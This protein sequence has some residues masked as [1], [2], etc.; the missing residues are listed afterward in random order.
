MER[1]GSQ[2]SSPTGTSSVPLLQIKDCSQFSP[3]F[4]CRHWAIMSDNTNCVKLK[5]PFQERDFYRDIGDGFPPLHMD[6]L[7]TSSLP[8]LQGLLWFRLWYTS[9]ITLPLA[10]DF[11]PVISLVNRILWSFLH[12][13]EA[14]VLLIMLLQGLWNQNVGRKAGVSQWRA[15]GEW[16]HRECR[17]LKGGFVRSIGA[18]WWLVHPV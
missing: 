13:S 6:S 7:P 14:L 3:C 4:P 5:R 9:K 2:S 17:A 16:I 1:A 12:L 15:R 11:L 8:V 18:L 10:D